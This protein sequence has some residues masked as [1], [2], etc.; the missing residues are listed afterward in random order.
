MA[1]VTWIKLMIDM[2]DNAK[3]KYLRKLPE[4]N[5]IVLIWIM[6]LSKAGKCNSSGFIFLTENIPY[7]PEM[8]AAEFNFEVNTINLALVSFTKLNMITMEE[9]TIEISGWNEYQNVDGLEKIREQTR[10]RVQNH[11]EKQRLISNVISNV[12]VTDSNAT[13][14]DKEE[15]R[16]IDID[17][18]R[19]DINIYKEK[20]NSLGLTKIISIK[21]QRLTHLKARVEEFSEDQVIQAIDNINS[22]KFLKGEND[23]GWAIDF[24]WLLKPTNFIKVLEG[25]YKNKS[26]PAASKGKIA[27][28]FNNFEPRDYDYDSLEKKLLGWDKED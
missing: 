10:N 22:S 21:N 3:I 9:K 4:G 26:I 25:N 12:T 2:F 6:L 1:K 18:K 14:E 7:T 19:I 16:D 27:P 20:W 5:N 24:D 23:R 11:R 13:E 8:L 17:K 15:E 28:G